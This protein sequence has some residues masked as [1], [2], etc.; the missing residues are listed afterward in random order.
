MIKDRLAPKNVKQLQQ[1]LG[2]CNYYR[3]FIKDFAKIA[4]QLFK[5]LQKENTWSWSED[6]ET[7]FKTL[8]DK[9]VS[10][11]TLRQPYFNRK[12]IL[13]TDASGFAIGA[14]LAQVDDNGVE[15][16][17]GYASRIFKNA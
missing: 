14:V 16:V 13:Y 10:M 12:F 3:K 8:K 6:C 17:V 4:S 9:L 15:Y 11:P 2:L 1:F 7:A 5:L